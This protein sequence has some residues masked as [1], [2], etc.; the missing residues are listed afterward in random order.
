VQIALEVRCGSIAEAEQE[1]AVAH[2]RGGQTLLVPA[3]RVAT[4]HSTFPSG[5]MV[6]ASPGDSVHPK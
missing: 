1:H 2:F 3:G 5:T 6:A 4:A